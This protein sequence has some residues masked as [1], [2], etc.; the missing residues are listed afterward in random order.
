MNNAYLRL[1]KNLKECWEKFAKD[2]HKLILCQVIL[3]EFCKNLKRSMNSIGR[4]G[5]SGD[6]VGEKVRILVWPVAMSNC[7]NNICLIGFAC[8][9]VVSCE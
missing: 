9:W 3:H 6:E 7:R 5:Q 8:E 4:D 1:T 2:G